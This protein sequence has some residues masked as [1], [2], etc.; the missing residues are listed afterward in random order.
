MVGLTERAEHRPAELSGGEQ[1]RVAVARALVNDPDLLLLD[2]PSGNLDPAT[3]EELHELLDRLRA[4]LG[5]TL[6][7]VTHEPELAR[8]A[9][10]ILRLEEGRVTRAGPVEPTAR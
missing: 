7:T 3:S 4:E 6:V 5:Q 1:Q 10:R 8:R 2:E 9:D